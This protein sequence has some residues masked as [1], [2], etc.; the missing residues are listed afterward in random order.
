MRALVLIALLAACGDNRKVAVTGDAG[1]DASSA[2]KACL[3]RPDELPRPP[4][5]S[6]PCELLPPGL[7][8]P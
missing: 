6:L 1:V 8:L 7:E 5:G 4:T 2:K 3:D